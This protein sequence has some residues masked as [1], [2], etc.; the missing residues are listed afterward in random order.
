[1]GEPSLEFMNE[2]A[3]ADNAEHLGEAVHEAYR[4]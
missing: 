1:M 2:S 3:K 4:P